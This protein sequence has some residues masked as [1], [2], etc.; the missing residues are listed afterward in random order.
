MRL[1]L[2]GESFSTRSPATAAQTTVNLYTEKTEDPFETAKGVG[3]V[4]GTPGRH[5]F[6]NASAIDA[7]FSHMRGIWSGAGRCFIAG[8]TKYCEIDSSGALVGSVRTISNASVNG[9]ANSPVQFFPNGNQLFIVAGGLAYVDNGSGPVAVSLRPFTGVVDT[10]VVL[11]QFSAIWV[12]GDMFDPAM[13]AGTTITINAVAYTILAY[14]SPSVVLLTTTAGNQTGVDYSAT[15]PPFGAVT[16]AY[17][18][19]Y[20]IINRPNSRQ[21]NISAVNDSTGAIWNGLDFG[22]KNTWPDALSG[23]LAADQLYLFGTDSTDPYDNT[24]NAGF[25]FQE[26]DGGTFRIGTVSPWSPI[27]VNGAVY[28]IGANSEG[29][30]VA[31]TLNGFTPVRISTH[32]EEFQWTAA[33]LGTNCVAFTEEMDGHHWVIWNF[34]TQTWQYDPETGA[35]TQRADWDGSAFQPYPIQYHTYIPEFG[36]GKHL[37]C[38]PA[39]SIVYE[40]SLDFYDDNGN[41][42][43]W[44]RALPYLY[45]EGKTQFLGRATLEMQTGTVASGAAPNVTLDFSKDRGHTFVNPR[46]ASIGAHDDF[47]IRVFWPSNG[48]GRDVIPRL[49]G[50]GQSKVALVCFDMDVTVGAA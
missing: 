35:W 12:S 1:S 10:T 17:M 20:Y 14:L 44:Q 40:E 29:R 8:G 27:V 49:S 4:Y 9:L 32:A 24:G 15:S 42:R 33:N 30:A 23:I 11:G 21:F 13:S 22:T 5:V 34:G 46:T 28:F 47:S 50:V 41:D 37:V 18:D 25:P 38:G 19:G 2:V 26:I 16:G 39:D 45:A 6:K 36:N 7:G 48:S 31:Y 43:K 3:A